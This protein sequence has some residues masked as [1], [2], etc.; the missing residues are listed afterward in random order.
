MKCVKSAR[1]D[2]NDIREHVGESMPVKFHGYCDKHNIEEF[3]DMEEAYVDQKRRRQVTRITNKHHYQVDSFKNVTDW[4]V[5]EIDGW[6]SS[7]KLLVWLVALSPGDSLHDFNLE[8]LINLVNYILN[9]LTGE[10]RD[11]DKFCASILLM[12]TPMITFQQHS[13]NH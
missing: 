8:S 13:D 7:S 1:T 3:F 4:L 10:M 9:I 2:L 11:L 12:Y 5:Q 6:F